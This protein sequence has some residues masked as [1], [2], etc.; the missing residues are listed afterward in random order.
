MLKKLIAGSKV[1]K[2]GKA[3][4]KIIFLIIYYVLICVI[5]LSS[6][7]HFQDDL[8]T[9]RH[10][11]LG[12]FLCQGVLGS[13]CM[14][15]TNV[16]ITFLYLSIAVISMLGFLP[17]VMLAL[18]VDVQLLKDLSKKCTLTNKSKETDKHC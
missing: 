10:E 13:D 14:M 18:Y 4:I 7:I 11:I 15:D 3:Q 1:G 6:F 12:D 16:G 8:K 17:V 2:V 5:G 9:A